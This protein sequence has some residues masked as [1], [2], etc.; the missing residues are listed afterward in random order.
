MQ[1][2]EN[3][4]FVAVPEVERFALA[5]LQVPTLSMSTLK[6]FQRHQLL[7]VR[8][9]VSPRK[10]LDQKPND[11]NRCKLGIQKG[12]HFFWED[13]GKNLKTRIFDF[14]EVWA[15]H[16]TVLYNLTPQTFF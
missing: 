7:L 8:S 3:L 12:I 6:D 15:Y 14:K 9:V 4:A 11:I 10:S 16:A 2:G 5:V 1:G 13:L